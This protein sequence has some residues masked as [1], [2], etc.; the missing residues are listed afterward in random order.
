[1]KK[2]TME[3]LLNEMKSI[4][5]PI[6]ASYLSKKFDVSMATVGRLLKKCED[7]GYL[8]SISNKGRVI[9]KRG[10]KFLSNNNAK[11]EMVQSAEK[12]IEIAFSG[13][14]E[15]IIEVL[16]I[17]KLV[18]PYTVRCATEKSTDADRE[19]VRD[20]DFE[21]QYAVRK[22]H[23]GSEEDLRMHLKIAELAGNNT[24]Y[25]VLKL[26]LTENNIYE[27]LSR[28]SHLGEAGSYTDHTDFLAA[29]YAGDADGAADAM[30]K[31]I[32]NLIQNVSKHL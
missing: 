10:E 19:S 12:V 21:H 28:L 8:K 29:Y 9:T 20:I 16:Q 32:D 2:L 4:G 22:G 24:L 11:N 26:L 18:E 13:K 23:N 6:G 17:R 5:A 14:P 15:N 27:Y 25:Q 31:H 30:E 7:E 3:V 1:M